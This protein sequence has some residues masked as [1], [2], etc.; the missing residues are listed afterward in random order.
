MSRYLLVKFQWILWHWVYS[1]K[2]GQR[3]V[4]S[5]SAPGLSD[6][7][8]GNNGSNFG[9]HSFLIG[10][11]ILLFYFWSHPKQILFH[12]LQYLNPTCFGSVYSQS[13]SIFFSRW[14]FCWWLQGGTFKIVVTSSAGVIHCIMRTRLQTELCTA[15]SPCRHCVYS[16]AAATIAT[17]IAV[18]VNTMAAFCQWVPSY[19]EPQQ[20]SISREL[21]SDSM[22]I[23]SLTELFFW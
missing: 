18:I 8:V 15:H 21:S 4:L 12:D 11:L 1:W 19:Q 2:I 9:A 23:Q 6:G 5:L 7:P 14:S 3:A 16:L 13:Q 17:S 22:H 10:S 20:L